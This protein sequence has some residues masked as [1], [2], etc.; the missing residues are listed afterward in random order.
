M[1]EKATNM[2]FIDTSIDAI[3]QELNI[4]MSFLKEK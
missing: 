4:L 1:V 3:H 2:E